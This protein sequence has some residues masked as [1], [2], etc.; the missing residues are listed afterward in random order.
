MHILGKFNLKKAV[1]SGVTGVKIP[2][3][4]NLRIEIYGLL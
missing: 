4:K 2:R 1:R 3:T